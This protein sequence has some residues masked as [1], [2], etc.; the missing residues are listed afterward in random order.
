MEQERKDQG[1]GSTGRRSH[2]ERTPRLKG[3]RRRSEKHRW[4]EATAA[5][6]EVSWG[7]EGANGW[8]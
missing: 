2:P 3:S 1:R 5:V 7:V 4:V 6:L 8:E